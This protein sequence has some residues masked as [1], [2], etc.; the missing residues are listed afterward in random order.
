MKL[1]IY[2]VLIYLAYRFFLQPM[3]L[4]GKDSKSAR[5]REED[6]KKDENGDYVDYEELK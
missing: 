1:L 3:M 5:L 2:L 6:E 4:P